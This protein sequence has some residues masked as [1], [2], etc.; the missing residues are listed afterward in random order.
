MSHRPI[1]IQS[2]RQ[3]SCLLKSSYFN[4]P[5]LVFKPG[6][7]GTRLHTIA[8]SSRSKKDTYIEFGSCKLLS[9]TEVNIVP[10]KDKEKDPWTINR[11]D[12]G[13]FITD[14]WEA[15]DI[16]TLGSK[17]KK[18]QNQGDYRIA[19]VE[20]DLLTMEPN[21]DVMQ[22]LGVVYQFYDW[23]CLWGVT[24]LKGSGYKPQ[25]STNC[26]SKNQQPWLDIQ[27]PNWLILTKDLYA[28]L[29][30]NIKGDEGSLY[31]SF[32]GGDY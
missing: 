30:S 16:I 32:I 18:G 23:R 6:D 24:I 29:P 15:G 20:K 3:D 4:V 19:K 28:R 9:E 8:A 12:K 17:V 7:R 2:Y 13:D 27:D 11:L 1:F 26:L 14:G 5:Q 10:G 25:A 21:S 31:L 22:I